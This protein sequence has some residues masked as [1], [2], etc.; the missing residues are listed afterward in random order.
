MESIKEK[1][2]E[3]LPLQVRT[4]VNGYS[5]DVNGEG[6]LYHDFQNLMRGLLVH[7]GM[8]NTDELTEKQLKKYL[9]AMNNGSLAKNLQM[10]INRMKEHIA[11]LKFELRTLKEE[12]K[13]LK[14]EKFY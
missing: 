6:Y 12:N 8:E 7:G 5:L 9:K 11:S 1:K 4:L 2:E 3:R 14:N 10:E 13:R